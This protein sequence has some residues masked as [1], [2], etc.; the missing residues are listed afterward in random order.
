MWRLAVLAKGRIRRAG[1]ETATATLRARP[2][3]NPAAPV[4]P[5]DGDGTEAINRIR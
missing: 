2:F 4:E 3:A 1:N 5:G